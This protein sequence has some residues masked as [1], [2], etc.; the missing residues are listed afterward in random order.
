MP[1]SINLILHFTGFFNA[2]HLGDQVIV[3]VLKKFSNVPWEI[4]FA[5]VFDVFNKS[6]SK[7][8]AFSIV[9]LLSI[10]QS[11][12]IVIWFSHQPVDIIF[13]HPLNKLIVQSSFCFIHSITGVSKLYSFQFAE[14]FSVE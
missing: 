4:N 1:I 13:S 6:L 7:R 9:T 5:V 8:L 11:S 10:V 14:I 3:V 2:N 12:L